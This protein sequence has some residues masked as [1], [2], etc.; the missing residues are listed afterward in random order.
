M[1]SLGQSMGFRIAREVWE[2]WLPAWIIQDGNY[3]DLTSGQT[4]EFAVEFWC[5]NSEPVVAQNRELFVRKTKNSYYQTIAEVVLQTAAIA[6]LDVGIHVY[7]EVLD[8]GRQPFRKGDRVMG[9]LGLCVDP[10]AY[11][12]SLSKCAEIPPLVYSWRLAS[13]AKISGPWLQT[14]NERGQLLQIRDHEQTGYEAIDRTD[15]W[16]DDD[17][18]AEYLLSCE[19]LPFPPTRHSATAIYP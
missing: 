15:A 2:I 8:R 14:R 1:D 9:E 7:R 3:P 6:V 13:I 4:A 16:N 10:F 17:G 5:R 11:F 19:L 12:E 18:C